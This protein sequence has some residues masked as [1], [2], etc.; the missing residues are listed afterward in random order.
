[1]RSYAL[2][3]SRLSLIRRLIAAG[4]EV[5]AAAAPDGSEQEL[6][7]VGCAFLPTPFRQGGLAPRDDLVAMLRV[8]RAIRRLRPDVVHA[9]GVK[10]LVAA[11]WSLLG[12]HRARP[13]LL[14]TITGRGGA[15]G[16]ATE[17]L[18]R[19]G[20][21]SALRRSDRIVFQNG[22][23]AAAFVER[24]WADEPRC[25]VIVGAGVDTRAFAPTPDRHASGAPTVLMVARLLE[26]KGIRA[27]ARTAAR[28]RAHR[29]D[30]R[31]LLAGEHD[32]AR[33]DAVPLDWL[34][35]QSDVT[36]LGRLANVRCT[37]AEADVFL[38]PSTYGEG[39]PR[40]V[41]EAA[42]MGVPT[43]AYDVPGVREAV[44]HGT[45]GL[46]L[47]AGDEEALATHTLDLLDDASERDHLGREARRMTVE[48]FD[49]RQVEA[50]Y[51]EEYRRLGIPVPSSEATK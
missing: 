27:F 7:D 34:K 45:T 29:P 14:A 44:A 10:P 33:S 15:H 22:D 51:L 30:V 4:H 12:R 18:S 23:D 48:R 19:I 35:R 9:F 3:R 28:V 37:L 39:V 42:S 31:F 46:L 26:D 49:V 38:F 8:A 6:H 2:T 32:P 17:G 21:P 50:R 5:T 36:Y 43:V 16:I 20:L 1:M 13:R 41:M 47:P 25:T 11:S 40:V 24:G